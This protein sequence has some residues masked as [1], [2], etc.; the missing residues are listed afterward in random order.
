MLV[1]GMAEHFA[2]LKDAVSARNVVL[3][4]DCLAPH[5]GSVNK[6][7]SQTGRV[8]IQGCSLGSSHGPWGFV[9]RG[10]GID[11]TPFAT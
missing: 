1:D 8:L 5:L 6:R 4:I 11:R 7:D 2:G 3:P 10:M 9:G